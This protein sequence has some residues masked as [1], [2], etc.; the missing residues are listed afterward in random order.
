MKT[1]M[2]WLPSSI[3]HTHIFTETLG[4]KQLIPL[5]NPNS[6]L[7]YS[8][9]GPKRWPGLMDTWPK[10]KGFL[11]ISKD[12]W[13][14]STFKLMLQVS[15]GFV[16]KKKKKYPNKKTKP[17]HFRLT[18][19]DTWFNLMVFNL[20]VGSISSSCQNV[21]VPTLKQ[22]KNLLFCNFS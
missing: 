6:C 20:K 3:R 19:M 15:K 11:S 10:T 16:I 9:Y 22:Q 5:D 7:L 13:W 17:M 18:V 14:T 8:R 21:C 1:G 12:R 2:T 4:E